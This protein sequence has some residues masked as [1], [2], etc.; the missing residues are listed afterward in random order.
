MLKPLTWIHK[1]DDCGFMVDYLDIVDSDLF[2][3]ARSKPI[4]M[5]RILGYGLCAK[6]SSGYPLIYNMLDVK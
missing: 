1:K 4:T 6:C 5:L 2:D 3:V